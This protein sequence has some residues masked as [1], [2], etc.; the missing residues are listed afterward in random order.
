MISIKR[1]VKSWGIV[2]VC[3]FALG[4][5]FFALFLVYTA[6]PS[7]GIDTRPS[8]D[9]HVKVVPQSPGTELDVAL[10]CNDPIALVTYGIP[11]EAGDPR[12]EINRPNE[13]ISWP[14]GGGNRAARH[15]IV[16]GDGTM[17]PPEIVNISDEAEKCILKKVR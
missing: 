10:V 14:T 6:L 17:P 3:L 12:Y 8:E 5:S 15:S 2:G 1:E 9:V 11:S 7:V 4:V 13:L 16:A